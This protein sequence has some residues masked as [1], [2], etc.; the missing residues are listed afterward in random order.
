M[1]RTLSKTD[2]PFEGL[3]YEADHAEKANLDAI[4]YA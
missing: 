2:C 1:K 4:P 3:K